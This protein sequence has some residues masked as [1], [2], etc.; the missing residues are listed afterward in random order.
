[1]SYIADLAESLKSEYGG[2]DR[3]NRRARAMYMSRHPMEVNPPKKEKGVRRI[4]LGLAGVTVD[5]DVSVLN[6]DWK[7]TVLARGGQ[8]AE[9]H[10]SD[11]LEPF[12]A[13]ALKVMQRTRSIAY[14]VSLDLDLYGYAFTFGPVPAPQFWGDAKFK[15]LA[16]K[17][18]E[19]EGE[20]ETKKAESEIEAYKRKKF[21]ILWR[22]YSA[23]SVF[24]VFG[25]DGDLSEIVAIRKMK[26]REI[27]NRWGYTPQSN[28]RDVDGSTDIEVVEYANKEKVA[29]QVPGKDEPVHEWEHHMD[30][31]P[32]AFF[33]GKRAPENDY[34][35][36]WR[37]ALFHLEESLQAMDETVTD[38]RTSLR[39]Q[40]SNKLFAKLNAP[41]REQLEGWDKQLD[42]SKNMNL[43]IDEEVGQVE[44]AQIR[45][46]AYHLIDRLKSITD[47][48]GV[49]RDPLVGAGPAGESAVRLNVGN[50]AAKSELKPETTGLE[51]GATQCVELLF[52]SVKALSKQFPN[53]PDKVTVRT[54]DTEH[55][56]REIAVTPKQVE[57]WFDMADVTIPNNLPIDAAGLAQNSS[58]LTQGERPLLSRRTVRQRDLGVENPVEEQA[59]IDEE[60]DQEAIKPVFR[61]T[62]VQSLMQTLGQPSMTIQDMLRMAQEIGPGFAQFFQEA[63]AAGGIPQ[64]EPLPRSV[65]TAGTNSGRAGRG[66]QISDLGGVTL[67]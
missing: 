66:E 4:D 61:M 51:R 56:S 13:G 10:A 29:V 65:T 11:V 8:D 34:G 63:L 17:Y 30:R 48:V 6:G 47:Q 62:F 24:P 2:Q 45:N 42:F 43:L 26:A 14:P 41:M 67:P 1:M 25:D 28:G 55:K 36:I 27:K 44:T 19:A 40:V 22:H 16:K 23:P 58:I 60:A 52:E 59:R 37:G 33:E 38:I 18:E 32:W 64:D 9:K 20:E 12:A 57:D 3:L 46:D 50:Q 35:V 39:D 54:A 21:P 31:V 53:A 5:Q 15:E 49:R 7:I